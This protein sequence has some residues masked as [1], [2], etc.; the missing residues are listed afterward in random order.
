M[1]PSKRQSI[2]DKIAEEYSKDEKE[3][4]RPVDSSFAEIPITEIN[5][6]H[7]HKFRLY[8]GERLEDMVES[9]QQHGILTPCIVQKLENGKYEMLAGHNRMQ[10]AQIAGLTTLPCVIKEKLSN[11]EAL[12]FVIETNL[13]QR[14]FTDMLPTE[15][16][17]V[18]QVQVEQVASQG[19]RNDILCELTFLETGEVKALEGI[20]A[21]SSEVRTKSRSNEQVGKEYGLG[22]TSVARLIRLNYLTNGI[23]ELIDKGKLSMGAAVELSYLPYEAQRWTLELSAELKCSLSERLAKLLKEKN[24]TLRKDSKELTRDMIE[25]IMQALLAENKPV[26]PA[27]KVRVSKDIYNQY[28][29]TWSEDAIQDVIDK[30]VNAW[31][32]AG[33]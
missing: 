4:K 16:A 30:A 33:N 1:A 28:F 7:D 25:G 31:F 10:A 9:V 27:H 32:D 5:P 8:T 19:R 3:T 21:T 14:S 24:K 6:F 26:R 12:V 20:G 22:H 2:L 23:R 13:M 15:Q 18:L 29:K 17:A 11:K